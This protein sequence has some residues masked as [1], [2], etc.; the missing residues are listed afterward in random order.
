MSDFQHE[1]L[2]PRRPHHVASSGVASVRVTFVVHRYKTPMP[3][4]SDA[5]LA[6]TIDGTMKV[7]RHAGV[8]AESWRLGGADDLWT[9]LE[10]E[11]WRSLRPITH[12]V[13][14]T[15]HFANPSRISE[16][17][18]HWPEVEFV[19]LNH[20]GLAYLSI[21]RHGEGVN[22]MRELLDMQQAAHNI[23]LAGNNERFVS[24]MDSA[25]GAP[26]TYLPN[27]YDIWTFVEHVGNRR[28]RGPLRIGSFGVGR[29]W[30]NQ[31]V[32]AEAALSLAGLEGRMEL[33]VN[34]DPWNANRDMAA[35][36]RALFAGTSNQL[37]EHPWDWWPRFRRQAVRDMDILL[38][39]SF[40]ET[41]CCVVADG[42]AEGVPSVVTAAMEWA[43]K[44]WQANEPFDQAAV[45]MIGR[46][47]L[48]DRARSTY[49]GRVALR[50]H[51][52][53][54]TRLWIEYLTNAGPAR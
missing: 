1:A 24:M 36:R 17:A 48:Y 21:D 5:G 54:G 6:V 9:R 42:I 10:A 34:V 33:H 3:G 39:P 2:V 26:A 8:H 40:D 47:H 31:L 14:N 45:A 13:I 32:A 41:H 35:C 37:I 30:K 23:R 16:M 44:H 51:V 52:T 27:L 20:T 11:D 12:V 50:K 49:D 15:P 25:Y 18:A 4:T 19:V 43:P 46:A 7:L 53:N 29:P 22:K 38:N 28:D